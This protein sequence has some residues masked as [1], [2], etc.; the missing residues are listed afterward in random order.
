MLTLLLGVE[1]WS[2]AAA[3]VG[4]IRRATCIVFLTI[5]LPFNQNRTELG[6]FKG[7]YTGFEMLDAL[8]ITPGL[9]T[10]A[11]DMILTVFEEFQFEAL[12]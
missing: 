8:Q 9:G 2:V 4:L 5:F 12:A 7:P 3:S 11:F 10:V 6:A 1:M